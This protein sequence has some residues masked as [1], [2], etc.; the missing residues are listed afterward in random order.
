MV[1][2]DLKAITLC[3]NVPVYLTNRALCHRKRK[4]VRS[5]TLFSFSP[6]SLANL[7]FFFFFIALVLISLCVFNSV[8]SLGCSYY[9]C[10]DWP[11]VEEDCRRAIELD[12]NCVKVWNLFI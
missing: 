12:N 8:L 1:G 7:I 9:L 5:L 10:R 6:L 11:K 3:P 4:Y 2:L